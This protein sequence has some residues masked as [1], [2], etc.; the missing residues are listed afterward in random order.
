MAGLERSIE[1]GVSQVSEVSPVV[2]RGVRGVAWSVEP[3][4][5]SPI[6]RQGRQGLP[7][8]APNLLN[9]RCQY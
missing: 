8:I 6:T 4:N 2:R 5:S 1:V 3:V 7:P 9:L